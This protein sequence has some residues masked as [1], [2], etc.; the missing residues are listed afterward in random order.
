VCLPQ[1]ARSLWSAWVSEGVAK[2]ATNCKCCAEHSFFF[3][4]DVSNILYEHVREQG[5]ENTSIYEGRS[6]KKRSHTFCSSQALLNVKLALMKTCG[7]S[8]GIAPAFLTSVVNFTTLPL[9]PWETVPVPTGQ[10]ARCSPEPVWTLWR[11]DTFLTSAGNR[12]PVVQPVARRYS[13][14]AIP[15]NTGIIQVI[16]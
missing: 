8:G 13:D 10:A 1:T 4:F 5:P 9:Y 7:G 11:R 6:I 14:W 12:A 3:S 15:A 16:K 2:L